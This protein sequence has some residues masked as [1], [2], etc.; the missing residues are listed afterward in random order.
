MNKKATVQIAFE[1]PST[2]FAMLSVL[3][4][5][6]YKQDVSLKINPELKQILSKGSSYLVNLCISAKSPK[7]TYSGFLKNHNPA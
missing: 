5:G 1:F 4:L 2:V 6:A 7:K 3:G